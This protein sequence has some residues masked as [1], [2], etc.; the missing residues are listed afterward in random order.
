MRHLQFPKHSRKMAAMKGHRSNL[1]HCAHEHLCVTP[2]IVRLIGCKCFV[3]WSMWEIFVDYIFIELVT[4]QKH[5][6]RMLL[7]QKRK[8]KTRHM[9]LW[10]Q[11]IFVVQTIV[12]HIACLLC[13]I[14]AVL[15][16][17][18]NSLNCHVIWKCQS[19]YHHTYTHVLLSSSIYVFDQINDTTQENIS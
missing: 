11:Y 16:F 1:K 3:F 12:N 9:L 17:C 5:L 15:S 7:N 18:Y 6:P 2:H 4:G 10:L 13:N 14:W 19:Q 8:S